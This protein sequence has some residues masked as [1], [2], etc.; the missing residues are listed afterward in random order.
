VAVTRFAGGCPGAILASVSKP[1]QPPQLQTLDEYRERFSSASYWQLYV[2]TVCARH[3]LTPHTT[4]RCHN[5]GTYPTFI[6]DDRWVVKF[7]GELFNGPSGYTAELD[8][9]LLVTRDGHIPAPALLD[10]GELL[11]PSQGWRWPYL[12]FA[13]MPGISL[14]DAFAQISLTDKLALARQL[15]ELAHHLHHLRLD[16]TSVLKPCWDCYAA[17]LRRLHPT[18]AQ[19]QRTWQ[20]LPAPLCD[21]IDGYLLPLDQLLDEN[22]PPALLHADITGDHVLGAEQNGHWVMQG[23]IDFGDAMAGDP[24]YELIPLHMDAF[25]CDKRLLAAYLDAYGVAQSARPALLQKAMSLALLFQ[26]NIFSGIF[27]RYPQAA[28]LKS[29]DELADLLW[30]PEV[31]GIS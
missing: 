20:S 7:F 31:P 27:Q 19:R 10:R 26:F 28:G 25:R 14:G 13:F 23:L 6:I 22:Q 9:N 21:Q 29:L 3:H 15:G 1:T 4:I 18:C 8:A 17:M 5:P 24:A 16:G 11:E 30:N 12:I 2:E